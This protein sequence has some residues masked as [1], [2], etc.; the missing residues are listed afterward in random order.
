MLD[1]ATS[2]LDEE[3][4]NRVQEALEAAKKGRTMI[5]IAHRISTIQGC[6]KIFMLDHGKVI[7]SGSFKELVDM[8]GAFAHMVTKRSKE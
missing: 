6:D 4:Q 7:E 2:A 8:G 5:C 1:E 3:S